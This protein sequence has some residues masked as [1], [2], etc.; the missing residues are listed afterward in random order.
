MFFPVYIR[1]STFRTSAQTHFGPACS[2]LDL[3]DIRIGAQIF[4]I[5]TFHYQMIYKIRSKAFELLR[6]DGQRDMTTL[7]GSYLRLFIAN[8]ANVPA[9]HCHTQPSLK[10]AST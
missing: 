10:S 5:G 1:R 3:T 8:K 9:R 6:L 4:F 2:G 7:I